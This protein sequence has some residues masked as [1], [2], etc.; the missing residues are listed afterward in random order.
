MNVE[1]GRQNI[2]I[3][4]RKYR[5]RA[6]SCLGIIKSEPDI[7]IGFSPALHLECNNCPPMYCFM[8]DKSSVQAKQTSPYE[9]DKITFV[10]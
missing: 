5:G 3:L 7:Y 10:H 9:V 4:F 1:M 8:N 6:V 2:I